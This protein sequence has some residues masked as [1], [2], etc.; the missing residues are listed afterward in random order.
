MSTWHRD[1]WLVTSLVF[2]L[3]RVRFPHE[4]GA[5]CWHADAI[6]AA[7][8]CPSDCSLPC[9]RTVLP[10]VA[11]RLLYRWRLLPCSPD[12]S[13]W[14]S[15]PPAASAPWPRNTASRFAASLCSSDC[16]VSPSFRK[17]LWIRF[18]RD[19]SLLFRKPRWNGSGRAVSLSF[20]LCRWQRFGRAVSP[21]FRLCRWFR[22]RRASPRVAARIGH[23][24]LNERGRGVLSR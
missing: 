22:V 16:L 15:S 24:A 3:K 7:S 1:W 19:V 21:S 4:S 18:G 14:D 2:S 5:N 20:R 10:N 17:S 23:E 13:F 12:V 9:R 6:S 8:L 11:V